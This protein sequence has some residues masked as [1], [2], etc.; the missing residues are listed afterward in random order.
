MHN[1]QKQVYKTDQTKI[2][3]ARASSS[4]SFPDRRLPE[5]DREKFS[6]SID[7]FGKGLQSSGIAADINKESKKS[8]VILIVDD[9]PDNLLVLFS[10]LEEQGYRILLAEDGETALQ[11]AK[12]KSPDLIL[13]DVLMP[14]IDGFEACRRL[15]A[16][17][18]TKEIPVIFLTALSEKVNKVQGFKL[19]GVDYITKP[20]EQEEVL[21]RIQ[22]HL[23]LRQMR[24]TLARQNKE[25]QQALEFEALLR[26]VTD[27]LRDSLDERQ[28]FATATK[29]LA[30][31]LNLGSCQIELYDSQQGTATI[32]YEHSLS[33]PASQGTSRTVE[34]FPELYQQL[35]QRQPIQL[36]EQI[37]QFTPQ[38]I[39]VNRL[40]CPIFD[41]ESQQDSDLE[42][43][44]AGII[45]NLWGLRPPNEVFTALEI[46]LM[47][48][49]ASQCAI[50]IRQA[51]LY[52][53]AK[54]Q[55]EEL[56]KLNRLKDDF[57]KTISHE[58]RTPL[59]NIEMGADTLKMLFEF[60]PNWQQ[61]HF[62][63]ADESLEILE[64]GYKKEIE[65]VN[66]LLELVHLDAQSKPVKVETVDL[67]SLISYLVKLF[68]KRAKQQQQQLEIYLP[69]NLP[70]IKT[71]PDI[72]ERILTELLNNAC[73]YTPQGE[74][75]KLDIKLKDSDLHLTVVNSG[76][77][78]SELELERIFDKFYRIPRQD[79]WQHGGTGLG[80]ALVQ[81]Q[82]EY[83]G[84]TIVA[85]HQNQRLTLRV[86]LPGVL[87]QH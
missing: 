31:V 2:K 10:Y 7:E 30:E 81:K 35:L 22:T 57:L 37:P 83:L 68:L 21:V 5:S 17:A 79:R 24:Q 59:T 42:D 12:T 66:D 11:I 26:R 48:Q 32:E 14:D 40:A 87:K 16:E 19:G 46:R 33:L 50:A 54:L 36:V 60:L 63:A 43:E 75:I 23:H 25:Q 78:L 9:A 51:R 64:A 72:L 4:N 52:R 77:E 27:K 20:S 38:G 85:Q 80:L 49:V 3:F 65:L 84:G 56:E 53:A 39:Q 74:N 47:Q 58:L 45:G 61:Q 55:V 28:I 62:N 86:E 67:N 8:E 69:D 76:V 34:D 18:S 82:V 13:L 70:Q 71:D 73:K 15:K 29:E 6:Q 41:G 44:K 1:C